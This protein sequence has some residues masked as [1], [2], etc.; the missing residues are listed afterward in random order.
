MRTMSDFSLIAANFS[1]ASPWWVTF[2]LALVFAIDPCAILTNIAAIGY[3]SRDLD[4]P[5]RVFF[6]GLWYTLGRTLAF[7]VLGAA[8]MLLLRGGAD[9]LHIQD[10]F[11]EYGELMLAPFLVLMGVLMFAAEFLPA[12]KGGALSGRVESRVK[13][14]AVG[15]LALG[16]VLS[17][18][19]CPTNAALFFGMMAQPGISI[20]HV[21]F[22]AVVVALPVLVIAWILAF[23][24]DSISRFYDRVRHVGKWF[25]WSVGA[26][27]IALGVFFIIEHLCEA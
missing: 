7:G 17:L 24:Y 8:L 14:N 21:V 22:F 20:W 10:F 2:L 25:R 13:P 11:A 5:K 16:S 1:D 19:F 23:S 9:I 3:V 27:F 6:N 26:L 12:F 4:N 18:A 15:S